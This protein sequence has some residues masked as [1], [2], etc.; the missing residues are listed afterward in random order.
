MKKIIVILLSFLTGLTAFADTVSIEVARAAAEKILS[1]STRGGVKLT[2]VNESDISSTRA[3]GDPAYYIFNSSEGGFAMISA[4]DAAHPVLAYSLEGSFSVDSSMPENLAEWLGAYRSQI[5]ECRRNGEEA[6]G[7]VKAEWDALLGGRKTAASTVVDL[8]TPEWGQGAPFNGKCPKI[9]NEKTL[10]GCTAVAISEVMSYYN[11]PSSGTGTLPSYVTDEN[12]ITVPALTLGEEYRWNEMLASYKDVSYTSA[13]A[14]AVSTL[15]YHVAVL[16]Q[17]DFDL[18]GTGA[19]LGDAVSALPG[20]MLY[21]R[22][23]SR[24]SK[25]FL[26]AEE[27]RSLLTDE[28]DAGRPI[29]M[30]GTSSAGGAHAFV[31]DGYDSDGKFLMNWGWNGTSNGFYE[32]SALGSYTLNQV[33]HIGIRPDV[34]GSFTT[35]LQMKSGLSNSGVQFNG[36]TYIGG[37]IY[38]DSTFYV[39]VGRVFNFG[40]TLFRGYFNLALM[41]KTGTRKQWVLNSTGKLLSFKSNNSYCVWD[42]LP[43]K[44]AHSVT[45]EPGD[46]IQAFCKPEGTSEWKPVFYSLDEADGV[47]G[48]MPCFVG[49][50]CSMEYDRDT[51]I[52][53]VNFFPSEWSYCSIT[54]PS[55]TS[56]TKVKKY[57]KTNG[58]LQIDTSTLAKGTYTLYLKF[59]GVKNNAGGKNYKQEASVKFTL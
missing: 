9:G 59:S 14:E 2:L 40:D 30:S 7:E 28:L 18:S 19:S 41:S 46:C 13:Q 1:A 6:T 45:I 26:K 25:S 58:I 52:L 57:D 5:E 11:Y 42:T 34:G 16:S 15:C 32:L 27:W 29:L 53:T 54:D 51:K 36:I 47:C 10:V 44:I 8:E 55:G 48:K 49:D 20:Y 56:L 43:V 39:K 3:G 4:C 37:N 12:K 33:A 21:D 50:Y 38:K 31:M 17:A 24:Y 23:M 35:S 22:G